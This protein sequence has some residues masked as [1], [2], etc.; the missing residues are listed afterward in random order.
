M[1]RKSPENTVTASDCLLNERQAAQYLDIAVKT[2]QRWRLVGS[3]PAFVRLSSR[4]VKYRRRDLDEFIES[5]LRTSTSD[6]GP[7]VSNP[8]SNSK[9]RRVK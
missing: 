1:K 7:D 8:P 9:A 5:R 3:G 4:A 6:P 2:I